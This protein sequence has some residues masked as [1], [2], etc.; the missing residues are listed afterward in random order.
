MRRSNFKPA[1]VE[2]RAIVRLTAGRS[3]TND[4]LQD[5]EK[6][7]LHFTGS[8]HK[9]KELVGIHAS[10]SSTSHYSTFIQTMNMIHQFTTRNP[11]HFNP[12]KTGSTKQNHVIKHQRV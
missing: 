9:E 6:S 12:A 2:I 11:T 3:P 8:L 1:T 10:L 7:P 4:Y 5:N